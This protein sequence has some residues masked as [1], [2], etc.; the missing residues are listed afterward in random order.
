MKKLFFLLSL[1]IAGTNISA[2]EPVIKVHSA[3]AFTLLRNCSNKVVISAPELGNEFSPEYEIEG[4]TFVNAGAGVLSITPSARIVKLKIINKGQLISTESFRVR[5]IPQPFIVVKHNG[6]N[7]NLESGLNEVNGEIELQVL[8]DKDFANHHPPDA[9][10]RV[11][12]WS[13]THMRGTEQL[14]V[15]RNT[16]LKIDLSQF[17]DAQS[18]D[19]LMLKFQEVQR[20]NHQTKREVVDINPQARVRI[21]PII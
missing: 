14:N 2:Q 12:K 6:I 15:V 8:P 5:D 21:L 17:T 9:R 18:G 11:T 7:L 16:G 1:A 3:T 10:Y 20:L 19:Y 4:A 13:I